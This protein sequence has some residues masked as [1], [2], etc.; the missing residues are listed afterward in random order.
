MESEE[1]ETRNALLACYSSRASDH[2]TQLL[3]VALIG[4]TLIELRLPSRALVVS[5]PAVI[6]AAFWIAG[7]MAY[8]GYLSH[9]ILHVPDGLAKKLPPETPNDYFEPSLESWGLH[10]G[11]VE[12]VKHYHKDVT[13]FSALTSSRVVSLIIIYFVLLVAAALVLCDP[14]FLATTCVS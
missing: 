4:F 12:A 3:T 8:W 9:V 11:S 7:R 13:W 6:V 5:V 14:R 10:R 1:F 2:A